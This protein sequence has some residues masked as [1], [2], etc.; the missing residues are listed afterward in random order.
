MQQPNCELKFI[1][2]VHVKA[3]R[4]ILILFLINYL[5]KSTSLLDPNKATERFSGCF[6]SEYRIYII[7]I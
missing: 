6:L 5:E 3:I 7:D 1:E 4:F 2:Y